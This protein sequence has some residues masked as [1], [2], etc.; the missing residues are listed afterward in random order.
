MQYKNI[1]VYP[2]G[3][4]KSTVT[5][6]D[7]IRQTFRI[8]MHTQTHSIRVDVLVFYFQFITILHSHSH[9]QSFRGRR[10][11][12]HHYYRRQCDGV[13]VAQ[14]IKIENIMPTVEHI[15]ITNSFIYSGVMVRC[16]MTKHYL[17][18]L[19]IHSAQRAHTQ[20][21]HDEGTSKKGKRNK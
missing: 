11:D 3:Q 10:A 6:L 2:L 7:L 14:T 17:C 16:K 5:W 20:K 8:P 15:I 13:M 1:V 12:N 9:T 4:V 19:Y 21:T 18:H